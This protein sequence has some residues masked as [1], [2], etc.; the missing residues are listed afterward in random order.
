MLVVVGVVGDIGHV[1]VIAG[2]SMG[3]VFGMDGHR[4]VAG[5][6]IGSRVIR[7]FRG[8]I[9]SFFDDGFVGVDK[10]MNILVSFGRN[11][12]VLGAMDHWGGDGGGVG[13][14]IGFGRFR[15]GSLVVTIGGIGHGQMRF[16][17]K[18][19]LVLE[20]SRRNHVE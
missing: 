8:G 20:K 17:V 1:G 2:S 16:E 5:G 19:V 7:R 11:R 3:V 18:L 12:I 6:G 15:R 4:D 9:D 13:G 10:K 14:Y